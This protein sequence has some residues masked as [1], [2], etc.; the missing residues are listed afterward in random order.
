MPIYQEI[1]AAEL[2]RL[3]QKDDSIQLIDIRT[4]AEIARGV[5]PRAKTLPMHLV[6][7]RLSY[8]SA[9]TGRFVIY[10]RTG[11]RSAQVC[12]FLQQHG[13]DNVINLRGGVVKWA[14]SGNPLNP[15]PD[16]RIV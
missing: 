4:S 2:K 1:D 14:S 13:I 6:P 10:C 16:A 9:S 7:L 11:S 5:L 3:L 12:R 8:F 15:R